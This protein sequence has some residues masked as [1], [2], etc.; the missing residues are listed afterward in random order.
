MTNCKVTLESQEMD[1]N[2]EDYDLTF[3]SEPNDILAALQPA[4]LEKT[5]FN[6]KNED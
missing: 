5:G 2:L 6:I 3:D 1:Y 4:I